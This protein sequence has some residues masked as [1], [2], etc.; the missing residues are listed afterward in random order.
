MDICV[1]NLLKIIEFGKIKSKNY[2]KTSKM[3][4]KMII[5]DSDTID[6][7]LVKKD[8]TFVASMYDSHFDSIGQVIG[9]IQRRNRGKFGSIVRIFNRSRD[10]YE[11]YTLNGRIE[12]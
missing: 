8:G 10:L 2:K 12:L 4:R 1:L 7:T 3:K 5:K 11:C 9:E 6:A